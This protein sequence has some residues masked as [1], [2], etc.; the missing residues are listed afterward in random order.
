MYQLTVRRRFSAAH[1][2]RDYDGQCARLHGHNYT[3]EITV[4]GRELDEVGMLMDFGDLKMICDAV[5]ER[6][7]HAYLNDLD[8]FQ[9]QNVT[10]E[11]L[12]AEIFHRVA[13]RLD[14][15]GIDI[16]H[17]I[18]YETPDSAVTYTED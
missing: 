3:A 10:S 4:E 14:Q 1:H 17:I 6:Y 9:K 16:A 18:L 11:N 7:D 15:P 13:E 2:L 12:A 8:E 5:L